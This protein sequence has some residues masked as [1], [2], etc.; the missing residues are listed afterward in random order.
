[1]KNLKSWCAAVGA[2]SLVSAGLLVGGPAALGG[3]AVAGAAAT[4]LKIAL[5]IPVTG[6]GAIPRI[7][8]DPVKM[9]VANLKKKGVKV[10]ETVYDAGLTPQ[11]AITATQD[12]LQ[13]KPSVIIGLPVIPQIL[14]VTKML[15]KAQVPLLQLSAGDESD[16]TGTTKGAS[17]WSFRVGIANS[18]EAAAGAQ[19]IVNKLGKK[20]V[21]IMYET[22]DPPGSE[23]DAIT[24]V[25]NQAGGKVVATQGYS[26]A[27]TD[28]TEQ[29]LAMKTAQAIFNWGYPDNI[30]LALKQQFQ[31]NITVPTM[32]SQSGV[33]GYLDGLFT[34]PTQLVNFYSAATCN[35]EGQQNAKLYAWA[36]Q[37]KKQFGFTPDMNSAEAYDAVN[38]AQAAVSPGGGAKAVLKRLETKPFSGLCQTTYKADA[39]HNMGHTGVV[40]GF[41]TKTPQTMYSY[42]AKP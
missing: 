32:S 5:V 21:G 11:Q 1:M 38:I 3:S 17:Q 14:A 4:P 9:A 37:F 22:A 23:V 24:K 7:Y 33:T 41:K 16:Y 28:L 19:Y 10:T 34:D 15:D 25:V 31:N 6:T 40:I 12:A 35:P 42:T 29:V 20:N 36:K 13:S 30:S 18:V 2:G 39:Q 8:E 26:Y 27:A